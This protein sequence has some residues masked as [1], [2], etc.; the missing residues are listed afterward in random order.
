MEKMQRRPQSCATSFSNVCHLRI[1]YSEVMDD[2]K[3]S[4][5]L[6]AGG[7]GGLRRGAAAVGAGGQIPR[8]ADPRAQPG[9]GQPVGDGQG[10]VFPLLAASPLLWRLEKGGSRG[11]LCLMAL[12]GAVLALA[13]TYAPVP[14]AAVAAM[15][16]GGAAALYGLALRRVSGDG[17]PWYVLTVALAVAYILLTILPP[18][19]GIFLARDDVAA[20]AAIPF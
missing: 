16:I 8:P 20:L 14:P 3:P 9:A 6:S 1:G 13:L 19:G 4:G 2:E 5:A 15:A 10:C 17:L 11:G 12:T 18:G 7:S